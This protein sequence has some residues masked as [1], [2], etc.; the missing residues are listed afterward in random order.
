MGKRRYI[1]ENREFSPASVSF[2]SSVYHF[3]LYASFTTS[4]SQLSYFVLFTLISS[5]YRFSIPSYFLLSIF[6]IL[7]TSEKKK[8]NLPHFYLFEQHLPFTPYHLSN[9]LLY[10]PRTPTHT[11]L[12]SFFFCTFS[13]NS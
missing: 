1:K 5:P 8:K 7:L 4:I 13:P 9:E 12:T 6:L 2:N 10:K 11:H 3:P